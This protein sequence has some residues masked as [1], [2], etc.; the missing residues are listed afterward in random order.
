MLWIKT[1]DKHRLINVSGVIVRG[2]KVVGIIGSGILDGL[3]NN[4]L[5]KYE[6][7]DRA[8]ELL[9]EILTKIQESTGVSVT[10]VMPEK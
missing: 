9:N 2:K 6:T 10:F 1:Q 4:V 7:N 5:G 3:D 8:L